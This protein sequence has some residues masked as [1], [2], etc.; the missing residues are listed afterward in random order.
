MPDAPDSP[1]ESPPPNQHSLLGGVSPEELFA[2]AMHTVKMSSAGAGA[3]LPPTP[4]EAAQLFPG[5]EVLDLLG[6]GGMGAVY[7]ARQIELDRLVAIKL[8]PLEIS[9]DQDF[10]DRFRREARAMA[11]LN[12]PNIITVYDFGTTG[13]GHLFFVMEYVEGAN[14]SDVIHRVGVDGDQALSIVE[15]VCTALAYAHLKGVVHRDVKP[16]NVMIDTESHVKVADFGLARLV[17][18]NAAA[19]GQTV[20]GTVMG[21]PDYMAP[22]QMEGMGVDHRADIYSVGVML[23][24]MLC[25]QVPKGIFHPPSARTGCDVRIDEIVIK[26][27]QQAPSDRYQST[28]EMKEAVSAARSPGAIAPPVHLPEPALDGGAAE[29]PPPPKKS[30]TPLYAGLAAGV[31][32]LAAGAAFIFRPKPEAPASPQ[33]TPI[34]QAAQATYPERPRKKALK[35]FTANP[36]TPPAANKGARVEQSDDGQAKPPSNGPAPASLDAGWKSLLA[37]VDIKRDSLMSPWTMENG[38][39]R[40]PRH[41]VTGEDSPGSHQTL[42]F[43]MPNPAGAYDLRYRITRNRP[44]FAVAIAFVRDGQ[45]ADLRIDGGQ[46]FRIVPPHRGKEKQDKLWLPAGEPHEVLLEVRQDRIRISHDG[47]VL[48]DQQGRLPAG[49]HDSAFFPSEKT[50]WPFIGIGV[51]GGDITIRSAE[52]R[53]VDKDGKPLR[54]KP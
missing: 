2:R 22:E 48:I 36:A 7:R 44:G 1:E 13:E 47:H 52:F 54:S 5:Y 9:V 17:D 28:T 16:A 10:V 18:T 12:H 41:D 31:L 27:M 23:Y 6:R 38:E 34:P 49:P 21:T 25:R 26:A 50:R 43:R 3:W 37:E 40:S 39:L 19:H 32:A 29:L 35:F 51:C 24:E 20:T 42:V 11:K 15:Q 53:E 8:L 46:G 14:L 4:E 30:R 33:I 45:G